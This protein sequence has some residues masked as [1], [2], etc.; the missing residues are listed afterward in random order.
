MT[1]AEIIS[2]ARSYVGTP[3]QDKGRRAGQGMDCVGLVLC[4]AHDLNAVDKNGTPFTRTMYNDYSGQPSG[5]YV[6]LTCIKH[7]DVKAVTNMKPGDVVTMALPSAPCH[8]GFVGDS[9]DGMT[10]IHAYNGGGKKCMEH[11]I[12][13]EWKRRIVGC[14]GVPGVED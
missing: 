11:V 12:S 1:R 9:P 14:F 8:V 6:H 2:T 13:P 5:N 4:V 10:I 3:F 7:L